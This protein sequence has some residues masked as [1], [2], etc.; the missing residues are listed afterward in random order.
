MISKKIISIRLSSNST[1]CPQNRKERLSMKN[2]KKLMVF[3]KGCSYK[4]RE[5]SINLSGKMA[6]CLRNLVWAA[7]FSILIAPNRQ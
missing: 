5:Q 1:Q 3:S 6:V 4:F 2:S 7:V